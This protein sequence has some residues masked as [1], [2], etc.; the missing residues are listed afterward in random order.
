MDLIYIVAEFFLWVF[1][2][3]FLF[4]IIACIHEFLWRLYIKLLEKKK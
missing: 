4:P 1:I 3:V 2:G